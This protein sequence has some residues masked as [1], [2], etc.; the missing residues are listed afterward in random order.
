M[1]YGIEYSFDEA[2]EY[3]VKVSCKPKAGGRYV[4]ILFLLI[5]A[6]ALTFR[7]SPGFR[8][9]LLPGDGAVTEKALIGFFKNIKIGE[10]LY[11][12]TAA[13]CREIIIGAVY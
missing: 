12:A 1:G 10:G 4:A 2:K 13:F 3:P 11:E 6:F 9:A 5:L 7:F 8:R